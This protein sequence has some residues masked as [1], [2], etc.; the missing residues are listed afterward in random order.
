MAEVTLRQ[1]LKEKNRAAQKV[2]TLRDRIEKFNQRS[3]EKSGFDVRPMIGE[4]KEATERLIAIKS[5]INAANQPQQDL[6]YRNAELR[7]HAAWLRGMVELTQ[8]T[9]GQ[10]QDVTYQVPPADFASNLEKVEAEL[11]EIQAKLDRYNI[12]TKVTIPD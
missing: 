11:D 9:F 2:R 6:I 10:V 8:Y 1:A 7:G 4:A 3:A 12:E 5:A